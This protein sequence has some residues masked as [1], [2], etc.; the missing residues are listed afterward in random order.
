[1]AD[2]SKQHT[3]AELSQAEVDR[4]TES[5]P[6]EEW[7]GSEEARQGR[8]KDFSAAR[9]VILELEKNI[10]IYLDAQEKEFNQADKDR[11]D[12]MREEAKKIIDAQFEIKEALK[13]L[14]AFEL[15]IFPNPETMERDK[16]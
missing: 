3:R 16:V 15:V 11:K 9:D 13:H 14:R 10:N 4:L 6:K 12:E 8:Y 5:L 2:E 1:M 7:V